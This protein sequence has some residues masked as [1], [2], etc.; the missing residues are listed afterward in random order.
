MA[1]TTVEAQQ[2]LLCVCLQDREGAQCVMIGTTAV[3]V[4]TRTAAAGA[5]LPLPV[6]CA[7]RAQD[8]L[9]QA[10]RAIARLRWHAALRR[11]PVPIRCSSTQDQFWRRTRLQLWT[12]QRE[13][14]M[15]L[16]SPAFGPHALFHEPWTAIKADLWSGSGGRFGVRWARAS[17][18]QFFISRPSGR[19]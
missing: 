5:Q 2:P 3:G 7:T 8:V 11:S 15:G 1:C 16:F 9:R 18:E 19:T 6:R 17:E 10:A 4:L 13:S 14:T 12:M